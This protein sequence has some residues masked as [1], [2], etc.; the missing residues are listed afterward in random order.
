MITWN[1]FRAELLKM[2]KMPAN[3]IV[4][5]IMNIIGFFFIGGISLLSLFKG[6][7]MSDA[8]S[9][10]PYPTSLFI[11]SLAI[12][13]FANLISVVFVANNFGSEYGKDTWKMILPRYGSRIAFVIT[14]L[15]VAFLVMLF[16]FA[17]TVGFW[18][19]FSYICSA[20]LGIA[21]IDTPNSPE[22]SSINAIKN[23]GISMLKMV[24]Y[25]TI[26]VLVTIA[27][28]STIGGVIA[29]IGL[30]L[31]LNVGGALPVKALTRLVPTVH[32]DNLEAHWFQ[33]S[34]KINALTEAFGYAIA[35]RFSG[36]IVG[37]YIFAFIGL[38]CYIFHRRDMAGL[39]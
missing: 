33:D 19:G 23:I 27:F 28:R 4:V 1:L 12:S 21:K 13:G 22:I 2:R 26:T 7:D 35:P 8:K 11:V 6:S 15:V 29:G 17:V 31:V 14:K 20:L 5:L 16:F 32:I 37:L 36:L 24:F 39:G 30:S 10:F 3:Q 34:R 18:V 25:G 9:L 38:A